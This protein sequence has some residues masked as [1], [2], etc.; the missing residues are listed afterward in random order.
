MAISY[1]KGV[2]AC[3][4]YEKLDGQFFENFVK[5]KFASFLRKAD[6]GPSRLWLQDLLAVFEE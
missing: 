4:P 5:A 2:I 3:H 6:K 1:N